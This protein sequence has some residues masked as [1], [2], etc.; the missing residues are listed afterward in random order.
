MPTDPLH[1]MRRL[2]SPARPNPRF[3]ISLWRRIEE[4]LGTEA[5]FAGRSI[6]RR[7]APAA[8]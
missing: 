3:A 6:L 1:Q 2:S 4:E 5:R 7:A 8:G